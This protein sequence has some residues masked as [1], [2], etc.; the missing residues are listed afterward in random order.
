M[1]VKNIGTGLTTLTPLGSNGFEGGT[2]AAITL[3]P[4][5]AVRI[6]ANGTNWYNEAFDQL[7]AQTTTATSGNLLIGSGTAWV[8]HTVGG[9]A[10]LG[11]T[12][13]LTVTKTN[14]N[15]FTGLATATYVAP[16]SWTPADG[17]GAALSFSSV[18][19]NYTRLANM[20]FA[21]FALTY[22]STADGSSAVISGLPV[23]VPNQPYAQ[24]PAAIWTSGGSIA[25]IL[26]PIQNGSTAA[27]LNQASAAAVT[28]ADLSTLTVRGC[29]IYPA[30]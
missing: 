15:S 30:A 19:A 7:P 12:G 27:F 11:A 1:V 20:V 9:D 6:V 10:T 2:V 14:G 17:S 18:S 4:Q 26:H 28:N 8:T 25:V 22:P 5:Q 23:A 21:Y 3:T 16:T 29:L 13:S 24:G